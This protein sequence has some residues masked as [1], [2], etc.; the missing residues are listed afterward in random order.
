MFKSP[1]ENQPYNLVDAWHQ[2]EERLHILLVVSSPLDESARLNPVREVEE[3]F[4]QLSFVKIPVA[5]I[6]LNPPTFQYLRTALLSCQF[7]IV[8]FIGHATSKE[9]QL[10]KDDGTSDWVS[11][12]DLASLFEEAKVKLVILNNCNSE[13]LADSLV[14]QKVPAVIATSNRIHTDDAL[15]LSSSLYSVIFKGRSPKDAV[16]AINHSIRRENKS[17]LSAT[18]VASGPE[19]NKPITSMSSNFGDP[20][21]FRCNPINNLPPLSRDVFYDRINECLK[22]YDGL[23]SLSSPFIGVTGLPGSGKSA[24]ALSCAWRYSWRFPKGIAYA[25]LRQKPFNLTAM[26]RHYNWSLDTVPSDRLLSTILYELSLGPYLL[27]FDDIESATSEE[28]GSIVELLQSWDTS[29]GGRVILIMQQRRPELDYLVQA[30]WISIGDLPDDAAID[31]FEFHVGGEEAARNK[32]GDDLSKIPELCFR[33]PK[34]LQA[35]ASALVSGTPWNEIVINLRH[36]AGNP[37]QRSIEMF[38]KTIDQIQSEIPL[39]THFLDSWSAFAEYATESAWRFI[40]QGEKLSTEDPMWLLQSDALQKL[41]RV[42]ILE[43]YTTGNEIQCKIHPLIS[44]YLHIRRWQGLTQEKR[45]N[46]ERLHLQYY[47]DSISSTKSDIY[48]I[49]NEWGNILLALERAE[50][51]DNWAA[52]LSLCITIV[53]NDDHQLVKKGPWEYAKTAIEFGVKAT[54]QLNDSRNKAVFFKNL[55][56]IYY[57]LSEYSNSKNAYEAS[58]KIAKNESYYDLVVDTLKGIGQVYYRIGDYETAETHYRLGLEVA[59]SEGDKKCI[60]DIKHQLGKIAYRQSEMSLA[61][62]LFSIVLETRKNIDDKRGMSK[63]LHEIARVMHATG[64]YDKAE[65]LYQQSLILRKKVNDPVGQ[66]AT[67]HQLGRLAFDQGEYETA[68]RYY[69]ES[70]KVCEALNDRLWIAHN[71]FRYGQLLHK[72]G[73]T[74][75]AFKEINRSLEMCNLLGIGLK[76][77]VELCLISMN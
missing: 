51:A 7:D 61:E 31:L 33:H 64:Q 45:N 22:I 1:L 13:T 76:K 2:S 21:F 57:R 30:N 55:G 15:L 75:E 44:E 56:I 72:L 58:L 52:I 49:V 37:A 32:L 70:T 20:A 34:L 29:L 4:R 50:Q 28:I 17:R 36:L 9:I 8:H 19:I 60:A 42:N 11:A 62:E 16:D 5:L 48:P 14:T 74:E 47:V 41:Q 73:R 35:T 59:E 54:E 25:S 69:D 71:L 38:E 53:G 27:L 18:V 65:K 6:K 26:L 68:Q 40:V 39:I 46:Y 23:T 63:T 3:I 66:Q 43:R 24:V 12:F 10:E 67:L 77:E